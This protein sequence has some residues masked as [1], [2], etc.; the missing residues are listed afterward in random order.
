ME[1]K[2]IFLHVGHGKTGSSYAQSSLALSRAELSKYDISY[3]LSGKAEIDAMKGYISSGNFDFN[4]DNMTQFLS[5]NRN[6]I[7]SKLLISNEGIFN[8]IVETDFLYQLN[9]TFPNTRIEILLFI[10]N[11]YEHAQSIYQQRVKRLGYTVS[12]NEYLCSSNTYPFLGMV[13]IL[14]KKAR[15]NNAILTIKNYSR[16]HDSILNCF[17][18]WLGIKNGTLVEPPIKTVNRSLTLSELFLQKRFNHHLGKNSSSFISDALCNKSPEIKS[19][20]P[21]AT[22][23]AKKSFFKRIQSDINKLNSI[24][25]ESEQYSIDEENID[26]DQI[27]LEN[28]ELC[29]FNKK[30]IDIISHSISK[31]ILR[32]NELI[33]VEKVRTLIA[34]AKGYMVLMDFDNASNL[35]NKANDIL[36]EVKF[37]NDLTIYYKDELKKTLI[38]ISQLNNLF[39]NSF[40]SIGTRIIRKVIFY[41]NKRKSFWI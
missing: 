40:F 26:S 19:E 1:L 27:E 16:L 25:P 5:V 28:H 17:E 23:S 37:V 18:N 35:C 24:I 33:A 38:R 34:Q 4:T 10:R 22:S 41:L 14:I 7:G 13:E 31:E 21:L 6:K 20:K 3:P 32:L 36:N 29:C 30:Q 15:N 12:F 2:K 39:K 9:N 8:L 11:P